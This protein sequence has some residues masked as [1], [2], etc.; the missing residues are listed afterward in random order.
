MKNITKNK[1]SI[2]IH[3]IH[4]YTHNMGITNFHKLIKQK[5]NGAFK[6]KWLCSYQHVYIDIN[7]VLHY[8]SY[9]VKSSD[10]VLNRLFTF[11]DNVLSELIPTSTLNICTDGVAPLAKL[12]LQRKRRLNTSRSLENDS[13]FSSLIFTPG[14]EFM[15]TLQDNLKNYMSYVE[16]IYNIK[17]NYL[18]PEIDEAELKLKH[19]VMINNDIFPDNTHIVVTNDA[20]MIVMLCTIKKESL[21]N[22]FVFSRS[23]QENEVISIGKLLELHTDTVGMTMNY[24]LDFTFVSLL[25]GNDYLPKVGLVDFEKLWD[26]YKMQS[27]I[28][29]SGLIDLINPNNQNKFKINQKFFLDLMNGVISLS[30]NHLTNKI[31]SITATSKLYSN[32]FDG[33]TWCF[34][35]YY[36]G[37]CVRYDYMYSF[38]D[39]PHPLGL[40]LNVNFNSKLLKCSENISAPI[41]TNLYAILVLPHFSKK[42]INAKYHKFME[43]NT[44]LYS[45]EKCDEC[46]K[47]ILE[48][49]SIKNESETKSEIQSDVKS[50][51]KNKSGILVKKLQSH[52]KTHQLLTLSDILNVS[53]NFKKY[54]KK[55]N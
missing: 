26:S 27:T 6:K 13:D 52:R 35:T 54:C 21:H 42:L 5:Y 8:C 46:N 43:T 28:N 45:E 3:N 22:I 36:T 25:M 55:M 32:Y 17:V 23:N 31:T 38:T 48:I 14:T 10:D 18:N 11:F 19:Q 34:N 40:M 1:I 39:G 20:D 47:Y 12:L 7:Y 2:T 49:N 41:N 9:G 15:N 44:I 24:N 51:V 4:T 29:P 53:K 50:D 37:E 33:L 16:K 30:K